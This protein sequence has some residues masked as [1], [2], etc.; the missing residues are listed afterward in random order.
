ML[1]PIVSSRIQP[2]PYPI[3][4]AWYAANLAVPLGITF[5]VLRYTDLRR[6]SAEAR[7][8]G[9]AD[10][11]DPALDRRASEARRGAHRPGVPGDDRPVADLAAFTPWARQTNPDQVVRF[12]DQTAGRVQGDGLALALPEQVSPEWRARPGS[13]PRFSVLRARVI[14]IQIP[15]RDQWERTAQ[16]TA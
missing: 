12:L 6:R 13:V 3:R 11:C 7:P 1:D 9:A 2:Q 5:A 15:G 8:A 10:Q 4:L 14:R 16:R